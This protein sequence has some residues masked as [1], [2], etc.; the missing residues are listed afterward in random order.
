[1]KTSV[2]AAAALIWCPPVALV[3]VRN[4]WHDAPSRLPTHWNGAGHADGFAGSTSV[5]VGCL[6]LATLFGAIG[7]VMAVTG[8]GVRPLPR[9]AAMA[10][11]G[12][13]AAAASASWVVFSLT[14][15]AAVGRGTSAVGSPFLLFAA[16]LLWGGIVFIVAWP[17]APRG[18]REKAVTA[19]G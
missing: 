12:F 18:R 2:V 8:G 15:L 5:L 16:A 9:A 1:M 7:I 10:G 19:P 4:R 17:W 13:A 3:V 6:A 11:F 14:A